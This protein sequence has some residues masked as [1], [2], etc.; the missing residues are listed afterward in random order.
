M[1]V[2]LITAGILL[3][4]NIFLENG[5]LNFLSKD[6]SGLTLGITSTAMLGMLIFPRFKNYQRR[7]VLP[8]LGALFFNFS[9]A[10]RFPSLLSFVS[11]RG[12]IPTLAGSLSVNSVIF[13]NIVGIGVILI[14]P[15]CSTKI[16]ER[17]GLFIGFA[18]DKSIGWYISWYEGESFK[19]FG[20]L[21]NGFLNIAIALITFIQILSNKFLS[22]LIRKRKYILYAALPSS[23]LKEFF[24]CYSD[25]INISFHEMAFPAIDKITALCISG[26]KNLVEEIGYVIKERLRFEEPIYC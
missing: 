4:V 9:N 23:K 15:C 1:L 20:Y 10:F 14:V 13:I 25:R 24:R 21:L 5:L 7:S 16:E 3:Y 8:Q 22:F 2:W 11:K 6:F 19:N 18:K 26:K 12:I 17:T